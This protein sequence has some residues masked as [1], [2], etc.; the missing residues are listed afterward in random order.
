MQSY[1]QAQV[2]KLL[3]I[4]YTSKKNDADIWNVFLNMHLNMH[5]PQ[6]GM[7]VP[8]GNGF[9]HIY[10]KGTGFVHTQVSKTRC[11]FAYGSSG[12]AFASSRVSFVTAK[13]QNNGSGFHKCVSFLLTRTIHCKQL[14]N[15]Y[16]PL[17]QR[18]WHELDLME[19][20][21]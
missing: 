10:P 20:A 13:W 6:I 11:S 16:W 12:A 14:L 2:N 1:Q 9:V 15:E 21:C 3:H 5:L 4:Q 19:Q 7:L 8:K 18:L 17:G